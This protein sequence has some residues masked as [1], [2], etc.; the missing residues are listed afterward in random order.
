MYNREKLA[1]FTLRCGVF[2]YIPKELAIPSLSL[3]RFCILKCNL[4]VVA[5]VYSKALL[6]YSLPKLAVV[7]SRFRVLNCTCNSTKL[8]VTS[9][10]APYDIF[11]RMS[12]PLFLFCAAIQ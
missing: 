12:R 1:A 9:G 5:V 3:R 6:K 10:F 11:F 8:V 7:T 4:K 2:E